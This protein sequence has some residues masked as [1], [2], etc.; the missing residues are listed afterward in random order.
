[1][2]KANISEW[3]YVIDNK[4]E[5]SYRFALGEIGE[6]MLGI[7][8]VN[9]SKAKPNE[10]DATIRFVREISKN[11]GYDGWLMFNV[12]PQKSTDPNGMDLTPQNGVLKL[13]NE[14][15]SNKVD[16]LKIET[17]WCAWGNEIEKRSYLPIALINMYLKNLKTKKLMFV[18]LGLTN[19]GHPKHPLR[20]NY[21]SKLISFD[22]EKYIDSTL[23]PLIF[24][25]GVISI[26]G[27]KID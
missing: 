3:I 25:V 2:D 11:N 9:P 4:K 17:I 5:N 21:D 13:N 18:T 15:V 22:I 19:Q 10:P 20:Q 1:M 12:F 24:N 23:K 8:G 6:K 26:D 14:I 16:D 27:I 7:I